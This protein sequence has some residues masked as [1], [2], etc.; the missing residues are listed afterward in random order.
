MGSSA[1][2]QKQDSA[3]DNEKYFLMF[4]ELTKF[5]ED[6]YLPDVK[7]GNVVRKLKYNI[8]TLVNL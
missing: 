3:A 8:I 6:E 5:Y 1:S 2:V 7:S 4:K